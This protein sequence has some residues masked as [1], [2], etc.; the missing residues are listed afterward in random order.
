MRTP[1]TALDGYVEGLIDGVFARRP[2]DLQPRSARNC[3]GC[4][5]S[6]TTCPACR[7]PQE[8]RL[9]LHP[10]D[11]DL[12]ELAR[13]AAARL[14][15]QFD[16]AHVTLSVDADTPLP[17]HVDPDRI[18]Q[19]LTNLLGNALLA[20]PAGGTVTVTARRAD[21]RR[22][23]DRHRHRRGP[24]RRRPR[25]RLRAVLPGARPT[26]R[27]LPDPASASRSPGESPAGTVGTCALSQWV[28]ARAP[29][30]PSASRCTGAAR[31]RRPNPRRRLPKQRFGD[32]TRLEAPRRL[33]L[34]PA[35]LRGGSGT[36]GPS[37]E[38]V[39]PQTMD[40]VPGGMA[41]RRR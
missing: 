27:V 2:G 13:R 35:V 22:R 8:Q 25:T 29:A 36:C 9:D 17:V 21:D 41:R 40:P 16:D 39:T 15:P 24:R 11:A 33:G 38:A 5:G 28:A 32:P 20:T 37:R 34:D 7:A 10:V 31:A 26:T 4:T 3:A 18:T 12:A 19:V 1:L 14:A 6:P 30:S 23:G